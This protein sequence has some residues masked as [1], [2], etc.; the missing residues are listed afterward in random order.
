MCRSMGGIGSANKVPNVTY[1]ALPFAFRW[2]KS[3]ATK[4]EKAQ[5]KET[6]DRFMNNAQVGDVYA[7]G[8]TYGNR[9]EFKI[10]E[11]NRSPNKK[12]IKYINGRGNAKVMSRSNV[13]EYIFNGAK[14]VRREKSPF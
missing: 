5:R 9:G 6:I 3:L 4:E 1:D 13:E 14:L 11:M 7:I 10:I 8:D 12:G 2:D